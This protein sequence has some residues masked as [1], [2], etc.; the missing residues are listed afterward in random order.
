MFAEF[1]S[2]MDGTHHADLRK[3]LNPWFFPKNMAQFRQ[4]VEDDNAML[5]G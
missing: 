4:G 3:M 1:Q 5:L 2:D